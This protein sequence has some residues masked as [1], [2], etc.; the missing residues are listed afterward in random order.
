MN[1]RDVL[2]SGVAASAL[3]T[4]RIGAAPSGNS[5]SPAQPS[6]QT[7]ATP[8][9]ERLEAEYVVV[10]SGAGGGTVA[11]RLAEEGHT[12]L[13]LE[14]GGDPKEFS[15]DTTADYE[16]PAFHPFATEN[17]DMRW[18]F[19]VRHYADDAK[20]QRDPK[21][22]QTWNNRPADGVFY[23]RTGALGGCTAHNAMILLYPHDSD[24]NELADLTG[25]ASWRADRMRS[26]FEKIENCHHRGFDRVLD[27]FGVNPSR[28]GFGGWLHTERALP[29][30]ALV[31]DNLRT[32]LNE[33]A[34]T[35]LQDASRKSNFRLGKLSDSEADPN[36]WRVIRDDSIGLRYTPLTTHNHRR[37]GARERLID[38]GTRHPDKL[39]IRTNAL[40]TRV[41]LDEQNRAT[42]VEFL[43]GA[44]LYRAHAQPND[45]PGV[46]RQA[47]ASREVIL[48]GGAFNTPQ[49]L[50]LS[51]IGGRDELARHGITTRVDLPGVGRNLQ[52][53]YE[54]GIVNRMSF[55]AWNILRGAT[56]RRGDRLYQQWSDGREG[57][58]ATNGALLSVVLRS[59]V[60]RPVPDLFCYALLGNFP[61]Y[62]PGYSSLVRDNP[63]YL[64]WVVLKGH[65]N[66][67]AGT[68][69]LRSADPRDTPLVNFRYFEEGNDSAAADLNAV[70]E[71]VNF[72]R[73][74]TAPLKQ[75]Q[76]IAKEELPGDEVKTP[77]Q[78]AGFV[79]DHAWGH[80]ASCTCP[81]GARER[82]GVLASNF[83]VHGTKNLRVA[84]ASVFPRVPGLFIVSAVYM[85]GEKAADVILADA[86]GSR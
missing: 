31:D 4:T 35:A 48:A 26:Y 27:T 62:Y 34:R 24:W 25:D 76:L 17:A 75:R 33:S 32:V 42:G 86:K 58:Y 68:V 52:D 78:I 38:V 51:G 18:D 3:L 19:F 66:N 70:V 36:D 73:A 57:V 13:L 11:A 20:Q 28:H 10:G 59:G 47:Y 41:I 50:M 60:D 30:A 80:H 71:G 72:V 14:A 63:N 67:T 16:V 21:Y 2:K 40:A 74:M 49:L 29:M 85:V 54:V 23:P 7:P 1:R 37:I 79:R 43:D 69:T 6:P 61:G 82:G 22:R 81:I 55:D 77:E 8:S 56:F 15:A 5:G 65:T 9:S 83:T 53:R 84:D 64:T 12:I 45:T 46:L 44:R 39:R